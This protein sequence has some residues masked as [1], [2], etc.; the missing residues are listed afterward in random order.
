MAL[1]EIKDLS[2]DVG[3]F[4][5]CD[6]GVDVDHGEVVVVFGP[7]GAGKT[8]LLESV[9]GFHR[10][11]SGKILLEGRSIEDLPPQK[12]GLALVPQDCALF[13]HLNV[14]D[15]IL[16]GVRMRRMKEPN[17]RLEQIIE[18]LG[19]KELLGRD[20]ST[21][22][23]G[24]AQRV[25][26]ARALIVEPKVLL[27]DEP[28]GALDAPLRRRLRA[29]LQKAFRQLGQAVLLVTHDLEEALALGQRMAVMREGRIE[30]FGPVSGLFQRPANEA[31][32]QLVGAENLLV[33]RVSGEEKGVLDVDCGGVTIRVVGRAR[34]G[35]EIRLLLRPENIAVELEV[36]EA[37]SALNHIGVEVFDLQPRG[38]L[39][40]VHGRCGGVVLKAAVTPASAERLGL[41]KG[42]NVY[43]CFKASAVHPLT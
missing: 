1:L 34:K 4:K 41:K 11:Q 17:L 2:V 15:N 39:V 5:L 10:L 30:Q 38:A 28:L 26:L 12:R 13:P 33:G 23:G 19:I 14:R 22:S 16:F 20:V 21:L 3:G 37:S 7:S 42:I 9:A 31:V 43:F 32:A 35:E 29:F 24:E 25:A 36:G 6:V 18:I 40:H 27:L 8:V